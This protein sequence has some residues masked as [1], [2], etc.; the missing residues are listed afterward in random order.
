MAD[1]RRS[2]HTLAASRKDT[3]INQF[4][5]TNA[6]QLRIVEAFSIYDFTQC[7]VM[8][9]QFV[10]IVLRFLGCCPTDTDIEEFIKYTELNYQPGTIQ[11]A[12]FVYTLCDWLLSDRMKP[13]ATCEELLAAFH[14]LDKENVKRGWME[15]TEFTELMHRYEEDVRL[16]EDEEREQ[17]RMAISGDQLCHYET[18]AY[19]LWYKETDTVYKMAKDLK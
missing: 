16:S 9:A 10:P 3:A 1:K 5:P 12:K 15:A 7:N 19:K 13:A 8:D 11:M 2:T 4:V 18:Y 6:L 17:M 14:L